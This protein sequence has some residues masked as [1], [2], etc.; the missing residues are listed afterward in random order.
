[1][2]TVFGSIGNTAH[3]EMPPNPQFA[4]SVV[5]WWKHTLIDVSVDKSA[6]RPTWINRT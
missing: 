4:T 1:M 6:D 3:L 2:F 5:S